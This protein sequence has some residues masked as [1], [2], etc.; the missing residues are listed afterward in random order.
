MARVRLSA[1]IHGDVQGVG[2]RAFTRSHAWRLG[3]QG[4]AR[5][6]VHGTVEV[7]AEGERETL[8]TFLSILNDGPRYGRVSRVDVE[9]SEATEEFRDFG[10]RF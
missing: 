3:L 10:V 8:R 9:W 4:Y 5:N 6:V 7:V 1:R 2:F